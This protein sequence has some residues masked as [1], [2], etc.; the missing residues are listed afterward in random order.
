MNR[1]DFAASM[2]V[3]A[4]A[5][6]VAPVCAQTGEH[7]MVKAVDLKWDDLPSLPKGAK[8]SVIEGP[9]T[10][11]VPFTV[12]IK[13]PANY[14]IPPHWHPAVERVTVLSGTFNMGMGDKVDKG[15]TTPVGVGDMM[16]MQP[17]TNHFAWT[18]TE[19]VI[20]L[21]GN[22]PWGITYVNPDDD[23]RKK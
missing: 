23:P 11:A 15:K 6:A 1:I 13:V 8:A 10:E 20:Q 19:T 16:I 14:T 5:L 18:D 9:L 3:V 2:L 22:G 12:R 4:S 17:K 21:N 7:K